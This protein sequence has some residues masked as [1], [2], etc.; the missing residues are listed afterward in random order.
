MAH[1]LPANQ[2]NTVFPLLNSISQTNNCALMR[3]FNVYNMYN[4]IIV[5]S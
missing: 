2:W 4:T 1:R 5:V 3:V